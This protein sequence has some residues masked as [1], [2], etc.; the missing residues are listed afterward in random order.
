LIAGIYEAN[1]TMT[2]NAGPTPV[3]CETSGDATCIATGA[4]N[5]VPGLLLNGRMNY[6][7]GAKGQ[8]TVNGWLIPILDEQGHIVSIAASLLSMSGRWMP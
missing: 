7:S 8:G 6:L 4:G 1:M 5:F 3:K 2:S